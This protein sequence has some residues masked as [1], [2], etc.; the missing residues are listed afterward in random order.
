MIYS[1]E[2]AAVYTYRDGYGKDTW[3]NR[4]EYYGTEHS[5]Y[6]KRTTN[7]QTGK[8][9]IGIEPITNV[10]HELESAKK[11][12][13]K[14]TVLKDFVDPDKI[15]MQLEIYCVQTKYDLLRPSKGEYQF[16]S[17]EEFLKFANGEKAI[18]KDGN[19]RVRSC[20]EHIERAYVKGEIDVTALNDTIN[21]YEYKLQ[22]KDHIEQD[23]I[24]L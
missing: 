11:C 7:G 24:D 8:V 2:P 15:P 4:V 12:S 1:K 5:W 17:K 3:E 14:Y 21:L 22:G 19:I 18:D 10:R 6:E 9:S 16:N 20:Y 23:E 13:E